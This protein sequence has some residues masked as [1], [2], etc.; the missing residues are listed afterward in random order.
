MSRSSILH[1]DLYQFQRSFQGRLFFPKIRTNF[2]DDAEVVYFTQR[3]VSISRFCDVQDIWRY[4]LLKHG[5][6]SVVSKIYDVNTN[7]ADKY[8]II[9]FICKKI[10]L[11]SIPLD[12]S[13]FALIFYGVGMKHTMAS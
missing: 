12:T 6:K 11:E 2:N 5:N 13:I 3:S 8:K 7:S 1:K 10:F 9:F 4:F